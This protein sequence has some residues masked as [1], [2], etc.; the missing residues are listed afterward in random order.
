M[1]NKI[2]QLAYFLNK[3]DHNHIQF[4]YFVFVLLAF[5]IVQSPSDGGVG[6]SR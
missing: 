1:K 5:L 6:P 2:A 4:A 3:I